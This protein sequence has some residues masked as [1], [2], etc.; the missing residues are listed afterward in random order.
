MNLHEYKNSNCTLIGKG[1]LLGSPLESVSPKNWT[2][3]AHPWE[4]GEKSRFT[5][6]SFTDQLASE[7]SDYCL[8]DLPGCPQSSAVRTAALVSEDLILFL[9]LKRWKKVMARLWSELA[10]CTTVIREPDT[11]CILSLVRS[12]EKPAGDFMVQVIEIDLLY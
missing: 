10:L 4:G 6:L 12:V 9:T 3:P 11:D 5:W 7:T 1:A 8:Y 2:C